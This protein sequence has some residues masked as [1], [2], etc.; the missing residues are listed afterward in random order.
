VGGESE[1]EAGE[2]GA[3]KN[4]SRTVQGVQCMIRCKLYAQ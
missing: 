2:H 3:V 1:G 4:G